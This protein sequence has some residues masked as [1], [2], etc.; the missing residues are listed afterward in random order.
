MNSVRPEEVKPFE[1]ETCSGAFSETDVKRLEFFTDTM[2]CFKCYITIRQKPI[3]V[4][5]FGKE[6]VYATNGTVKPG[7][8]AYD[9]I[10]IDCKP[11]GGT[12]PH[13]FICPEFI[14]RRIETL[15]LAMLDKFPMIPFKQKDTIIREAFKMCLKGTTKKKLFAMVTDLKGDPVRILRT[16]RRGKNNEGTWRLDEVGHSIKIFYEYER[17]E[18]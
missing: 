14:S 5:C 3:N 17:P 9:P 4:S 13:R 7:G 12:C 16:L 11:E 18:K 1:C 6:T 8:F 10:S 15:R 2:T